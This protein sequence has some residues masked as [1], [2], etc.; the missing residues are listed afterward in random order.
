MHAWDGRKIQRHHIDDDGGGDEDHADPEL[1]VLVR[2]LPVRLLLL[3]GMVRAGVVVVMVGMFSFG[4]GLIMNGLESACCSFVVIASGKETGGP[5]NSQQ[6]MALR[7]RPIYSAR[8]D[9]N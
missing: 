6:R 9:Y 4:H 2:A 7:V 5:S 1:P 3:V 8:G